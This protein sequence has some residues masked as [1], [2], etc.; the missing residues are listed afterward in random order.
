LS[1][2]PE[3][4]HSRVTYYYVSHG[5]PPRQQQPKYQRQDG[6]QSQGGYGT[7]NGTSSHA[8]SQFP[9]QQ[10]GAANS[11]PAPAQQQQQPQ[12]QPQPQAHSA[13]GPSS[14]EGSSS[15][16]ETAPPSYE[17]ATAGD[18]KIQSSD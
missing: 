8:H 18:H 7:L 17:A 14:G 5:Q 10:G 2:D 9:G 11:F 6:Q 3:G 4:R 16:P 13:A 1:Q 12:P 15:Q